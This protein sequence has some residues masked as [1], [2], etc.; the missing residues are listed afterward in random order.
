MTEKENLEFFEQVEGKKIRWNDLDGKKWPTI[1]PD[2]YLEC[3]QFEDEDNKRWSII[4][5]FED[6][7]VGYW[8]IVEEKQ[9]VE[10][11]N[12]N[13]H[14]DSLIEHIN[15]KVANLLKTADTLKKLKI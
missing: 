15:N 11:D 1:I 4:H 13:T 7:G 2:R 14:I 8:E 10:S 6:S 9:E 5:G 3:G 12:I